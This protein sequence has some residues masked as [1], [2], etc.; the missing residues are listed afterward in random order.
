MARRSG[1]HRKAVSHCRPGPETGCGQGR[2]ATR[3]R[4]EDRR[5]GLP[6]GPA[7]RPVPDARPG[8]GRTR[9]RG[10]ALKTSNRILIPA[11]YSTGA[12]EQKTEV[13]IKQV[14]KGK[15]G[16]RRGTVLEGRHHGSRHHE[17]D[18]P[19]EVEATRRSRSQEPD[20]RVDRELPCTPAVTRRSFL[21][22][23]GAGVGLWPWR[24]C[25]SADLFAA[26]RA[27]GGVDVDRW[28]G[29]VQPLHVAAEGEAASSGSTWP[30]GRRTWRRSTTSRSSPRCTA[31]RCPSRSPRA[32]RSPSSRAQKLNCFGPQHPFKK[33]GKSGQEISEIFPHIGARRRRHLHRPLAEDRGDQPR[34]GPHVHEHRHDHLRPAGDGLVAVVRP[35]QRER[36]PARLRRADL[37]RRSGQSQPIAPRQW[38][39]GFLPS[40]FQGVHFRSQGRPGAVHQQPAGRRRRPAARRRRRGAGS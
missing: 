20:A 29:V 22:K 3:R 5:Q 11:D 39:S 21:G 40:R 14:F 19:Q 1:G 16:T 37:D 12:V 13:T 33:F 34:P 10:T 36:R 2:G 30:A 38:H 31:S 4:P 7:H 25:C 9:A 24:R 35:G 6:G 23:T 15:P 28:P 27:G 17:D 8:T 32:S 26:G 18:L